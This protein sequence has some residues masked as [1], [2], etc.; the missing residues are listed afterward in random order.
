M[1]SESNTTETKTG[2]LAYNVGDELTIM[3][4]VHRGKVAKVMGVDQ[5]KR[6][7]ATQLTSGEFVVI[8]EVN[9]KPPTEGKVEATKLARLVAGWTDSEGDAAALVSLLSSSVDGFAKAYDSVAAD[10]E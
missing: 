10:A 7:Y 6:Q 2:P 5:N 3:R 4:G 9:T 8:N 1:T